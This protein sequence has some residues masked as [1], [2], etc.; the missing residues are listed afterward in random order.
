VVC[1]EC[2]CFF[3]DDAA[4]TE[5]DEATTTP[6]RRLWRDALYDGVRAYL[7]EIMGRPVSTSAPPN[8]S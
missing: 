8:R 6:P 3:F 7:E 1:C 4:T 5:I 2:R